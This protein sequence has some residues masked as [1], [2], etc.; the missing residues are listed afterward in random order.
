MCISLAR[1]EIET[2]KIVSI[3]FKT[4]LLSF[5]SPSPVLDS[6]SLRIWV[7]IDDTLSLSSNFASILSIV[8]GS[9]TTIFKI[10]RLKIPPILS[11]ESISKRF[12]K[13][14]YTFTS[15]S[16]YGNA[17]K[18]LRLEQGTDLARL[19]STSESSNLTYSKLKV[20]A[21]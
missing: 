4:P 7:T 21:K 18:L 12:L 19:K 5:S 10:L 2:R 9:H 3:S 1:F 20:F 17:P 14:T 15:S 8:V 11:C 16:L 13:A 6:N